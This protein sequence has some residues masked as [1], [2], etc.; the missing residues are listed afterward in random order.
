MAAV[1]REFLNLEASQ[2][3]WHGL[4]QVSDGEGYLGEPTSL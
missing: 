3:G 4:F 1:E 2:G